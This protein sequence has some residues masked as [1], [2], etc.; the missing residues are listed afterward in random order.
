[1]RMIS[2]NELARMIGDEQLPDD[3]VWNAGEWAVI[4]TIPEWFDKSLPR[5]SGRKSFSSFKHWK[6][7][8]QLLPSGLFGPVRVLLQEVAQP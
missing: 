4:K 5:T 3:A 6:K 2:I 1:M 8:S 7:E